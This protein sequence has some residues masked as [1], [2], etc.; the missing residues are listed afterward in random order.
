MTSDDFLFVNCFFS[1]IWIHKWSLNLFLL[2][3]AKYV[4]FNWPNWPKVNSKSSNLSYFTILN[5]LTQNGYFIV[6][7][8]MVYSK[9]EERNSWVSRLCHFLDIKDSS[10]VLNFRVFCHG[11]NF[12]S[13]LFESLPQGH[14]ILK[15]N[16]MCYVQLLLSQGTCLLLS[17][18][19]KIFELISNC[20]SNYKQFFLVILKTMPM[21]I[22]S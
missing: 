10:T 18:Y 7:C 1:R 21:T 6:V 8:C 9:W 14:K 3:S 5:F 22:V 2:E 4:L 13:G 19:C 15:T 12:F 17:Y 11:S 16:T 20:F